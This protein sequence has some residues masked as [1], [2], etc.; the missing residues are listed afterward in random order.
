MD[1]AERY[2]AVIVGGGPAGATAGIVLARRG[3]RT[4]IVESEPFPRFHVGESLLPRNMRLFEELGLEQKL[5]TVPSID[6]FG[7]EF[8][9][10]DLSDRTEITFADSLG[11]PRLRTVNVERGPFDAMMLDEARAAGAEVL[12]GRRAHDVPRLSDGDVTL[13]VG[14]REV[15]AR[16][17]IDASGQA[18]F[19]GKRLGTR[20]VLP[21][22]KKVSYYGH[23]TG[24]QRLP[25]QR[26]GN[27][28]IA[29]MR[30]GWFWIIP[31]DA[32]KTSIGL[33]MG[34]E[35]AR[36]VGEP[37]ER[38]L[39]WG[40]ERCPLMRERT[41]HASFPARYAVAADFS[42]RCEP[43][44]GP[45]HFLVGDAAT[46]IDPIFSTGV[47]MGMMSAVRAAEA[48][49]SIIRDGADP[50]RARRDYV[51]YVNGSS[52]VLFR[53][54]RNYYK[55][56]FRELL[57]SGE[58]PLQVHRAII[59]V[60]A[61]NVFPRPSFAARW[62]LWFFE[63]VLRLQPHLPVAPRQPATALAEAAR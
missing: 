43:F 3:L 28:T 34:H 56:P 31:L 36:R 45:G 46:F 57:V 54:V 44:A 4:L 40:I 27:P 38:M 61:G 55:H 62:R 63:A 52:S 10:G 29:M 19:L 12:V 5:K 50:G 13:A 33:V 60:L 25:G 48:I 23:F 22:L 15:R 21:D 49:V 26:A 16:Y 51:D 20:R 8:A 11:V 42:Y 1:R 2:D 6:K 18:T 24:V 58:G 17:L 35:D 47:C 41:R 59:S 9:F 37:P 30:D 7:V 53:F 39:A 32:V 14:E